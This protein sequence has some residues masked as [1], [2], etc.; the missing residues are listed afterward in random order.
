MKQRVVIIA[1]RKGHWQQ[2]CHA[3]V[4]THRANRF[5]EA[6]GN[7]A[8]TDTLVSAAQSIFKPSGITNALR[9]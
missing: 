4:N 1:P 5:A 8:K 6:S 3:K 2:S 7:F 9:N